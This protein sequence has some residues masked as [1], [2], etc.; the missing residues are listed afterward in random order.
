MQYIESGRKETTAM[1]TRTNG[2]AYME[3][4]EV[5]KMMEADKAKCGPPLH[6]LL[7][8]FLRVGI[9]AFGG[10]AMIPYVRKVAV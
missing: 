4:I 2:R 5:E 1:D 9:T 7:L 10:P 6:R 8:T 3:M